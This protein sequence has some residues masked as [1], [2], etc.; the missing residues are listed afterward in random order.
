MAGVLAFFY[1]AMGT[2]NL[3]GS[4]M[5]RRPTA[6]GGIKSFKTSGPAGLPLVLANVEPLA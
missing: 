5:A 6:A 4:R 1:P 3:P 2:L